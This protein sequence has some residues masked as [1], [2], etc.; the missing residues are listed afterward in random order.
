M[1]CVKMKKKTHIKNNK[2]NFDP[3]IE[4][5]WKPILKILLN[6]LIKIATKKKNQKI[7]WSLL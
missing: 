1:V 5:A 7:P 2:T 4:C 3:S 6:N